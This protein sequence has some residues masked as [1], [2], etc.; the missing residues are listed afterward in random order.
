M[1]AVPTIHFVYR[2]PKWGSTVLRAFQLSAIVRRHLHDTCEVRLQRLPDRRIP[3]AQW[4][5]AKRQ[6]AGGVYFFSKSCLSKLDSA[7]LNSLRR[8]AAAICFDHVDADL[9][10]APPQGCDLHVCTS[11]AQ[12][13]AARRLISDGRM[14]PG[15]PFV[16]LHNNDLRLEDI[17]P[18]KRDRLRTLYVGLR[19]NLLLPDNLTAKVDVFDLGAG[20][21]FDSVLPHLPDYNLHYCV[22]PPRDTA[23]ELYKPFLKGFVA[24]RCQANVIVHRETED[25]ERFL[26]ADYPYMVDDLSAAGVGAALSRAEDDFGGPEWVRALDVMAAVEAQVSPPAIAA[27]FQEMLRTLGVLTR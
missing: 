2:K 14:G 13:A 6:P 9:R 25:A 17:H 15:D 11:F 8:K 7:A 20:L 18:G 26:G 23:S 19:Q 12:E 27:R 21:G 1:R 16:L 22:R 24:A 3:G 4:L 5:W 10:D